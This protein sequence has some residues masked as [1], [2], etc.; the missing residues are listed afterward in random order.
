MAFYRLELCSLFFIILFEVSFAYFVTIDAHAEECFHDQVTSGTKM[1]LIFE[2]AEGGFLDIDVTI[3]G[4]DQKVIYT[5]ERETNGKYAFAAYMDGT[6][7]YCFSN[8]MSSMT[9]KIVK[10]SMDIGEPPKDTSKE[11]GKSFKD[12]Q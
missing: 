4:P 5:G 6:Y 2:V 7:H 11:E 10:F 3:R 8:K 12:M 1:G 9:P